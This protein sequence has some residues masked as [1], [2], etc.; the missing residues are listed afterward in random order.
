M[1]GERCHQVSVDLMFLIFLKSLYCSEIVD[2]WDRVKQFKNAKDDELECM[3]RSINK[4]FI[5]PEG[6]W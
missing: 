2:F 3:A 5:D 1:R 6:D 4:E